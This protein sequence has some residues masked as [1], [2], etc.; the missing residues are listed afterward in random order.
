MNDAQFDCTD[1]G[2]TYAWA[3]HDYLVVV[4]L[5]REDPTAYLVVWWSER[6]TARP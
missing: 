4:T 5:R 1:H 3:S 6:L 2:A